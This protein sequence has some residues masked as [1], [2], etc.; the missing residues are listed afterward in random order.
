VNRAAQSVVSDGDSWKVSGAS[1]N[2]GA[3]LITARSQ[4]KHV[5]IIAVRGSDAD[6]IARP[7]QKVR[8][9]WLPET[10]DEL[11][12][13]ARESLSK[14][15]SS[16]DLNAFVATIKKRVPELFAQVF[17]N[18]DV[19]VVEGGAEPASTITM[20]FHAI[21]AFGYSEVDC[22]DAIPNQAV[23]VHVGSV[24]FNIR[25]GLVEGDSA[26]DWTPLSKDDSA[27]VRAEDVAQILAR[28]SAHEFGHTLGLVGK[29]GACAWMDG[30]GS[31]SCPDTKAHLKDP[32]D[33][34]PLVHRFDY[35]W[36]LMDKGEDSPGRTRVGERDV[37]I[38]NRET[39]TRLKPREPARFDQ[40]DSSY[41]SII[42][43]K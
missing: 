23:E 41:L 32:D 9:L 28:T 27:S 40:F 14:Q 2:I 18:S 1:L 26:F 15:L 6:V 30:C 42:H 13:I 3:N 11:R 29:D 33:G 19:T 34:T 39:A 20:F 31:H 37:S 21:G 16:E 10:D 4:G 5:S 36:Y 38:T 12:G 8:F 43:P 7:S 24:R 17:A 22:G 35:G 25:M